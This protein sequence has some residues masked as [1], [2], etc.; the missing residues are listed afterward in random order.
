MLNIL[1]FLVGLTLLLVVWLLWRSYQSSQNTQ[2]MQSLLTS[3]EDKHRA[4]LL[5]LNDGLNKLGDRMNSAS[6]ADA[7]K[8]RQSVSSELQATREAMQALQLAQNTNLAQTRESVLEKLH[9]TLSEQGKSQQSLIND[10][11]LKA[12]TSL[13]Q[14]IESLSKIVDARLEEIGGKVSER[15]EEGFK[16]TNE[17]FMSVIQR[18]ATID[19]A[20]KKID[21]LTTNMVSLQE[22]LGDKRSRGAYGEV[23][24]EG[25]VRNV[26]PEASFKM[27]HT[28][29]NGSRADC[30][31]FLPEPTGTVAVDSKFPLENY[32]KMFDSSL[33]EAVQNMA[34]KQFKVDVKKHVDDI[35]SKYIIPNVT[36]DGAVMF[37][38]AEAVFAEIHAYHPEVIDYA[39]AKRVWLVSPTTL[40]AVLN[41]ARAV[42]KDVEMRKQVHIIKDELG[43]LSKDFERFDSRMKKLA[44]NIRQAHENAQDVH[45]TSQK[46]TRRFAQIERVE[47]QDAPIDLLDAVD[48]DIDDKKD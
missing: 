45:I 41:T 35:A 17:T 10:T 47:L 31:L 13:T 11:M 24:L 32:H 7:E 27:Q 26:L 36:S 22:L 18:L 16:K 19:E 37:I 3:L 38:P 44:D 4:M 28:F 8:L 20:Q 2:L 14:S 12:T 46:I 25:L 33:P 5:D 34:E 23:Q 40:M 15:L 9:V 21:G 30:A 39:M 43:K 6:Q 48:D 29:D 1:I 42:L